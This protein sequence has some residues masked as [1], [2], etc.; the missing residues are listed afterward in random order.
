MND[1]EL[2][3]RFEDC[4]LPPDRFRHRDHVRLAWLYLRELPPAEALVRFTGG[5]RRYAASLGHAGK[6]HETITWAFIAL[7]NER[8]ERAGR[9]LPFERFEESCPELFDPALLRRYY[10]EG[11]LASDLARRVFLLPDRL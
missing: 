2:R 5:L 1:D 10:A 11:T 9:D 3:G 8:M 7:I 6:Y 4:S